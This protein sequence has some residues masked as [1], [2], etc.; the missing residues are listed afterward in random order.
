MQEG[1]VESPFV[2]VQVHK[3]QIIVLGCFRSNFLLKV[4]PLFPTMEEVQ[5]KGLLM[6]GWK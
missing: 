1:T 3:A 4:F 5:R 6:D 2:L